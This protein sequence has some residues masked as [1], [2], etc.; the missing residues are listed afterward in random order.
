MRYSL[1]LIIIIQA[2]YV[3]IKADL[4]Q[5]QNTL[6]EAKIKEVYEAVHEPR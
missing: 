2:F 1:A 3:V 5:Y 4:P 6:L